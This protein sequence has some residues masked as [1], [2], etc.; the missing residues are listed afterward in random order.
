MA[1]RTFMGMGLAGRKARR[2]QM[3]KGLL[4]RKIMFVG[5]V[6]AALGSSTGARSARIV[7]AVASVTPSSLEV[8][9]KSEGAKAVRLDGSTQYMKWITHKPWQ[10]SQEADLASVT[11]DRC[12]EVD[13]RSADTNEAKMVWVSTEPVGSI[14]DPCHGFRK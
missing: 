6:V 1:V 8:M 7:G 13:L 12:V 3:R 14:Y 11:V 4:A 9:T 10:G 2:C 5:V